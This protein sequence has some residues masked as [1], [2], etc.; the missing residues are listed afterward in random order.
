MTSVVQIMRTGS[1]QYASYSRINAGLAEVGCIFVKF[2]YEFPQTV[3]KIT[4]N[5]TVTKPMY[6]VSMPHLANTGGTLA[7][8]E[9]FVV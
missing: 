4:G 5:Y 8:S 3:F 6:L 2:M 7:T 9:A 1:T